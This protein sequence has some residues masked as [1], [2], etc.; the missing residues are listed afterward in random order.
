MWQSIPFSVPYWL[1]ANC[2]SCLHSTGGH[3]TKVRTLRS[4]NR[5]F[6]VVGGLS[7]LGSL[8]LK[9]TLQ[10]GQ[11]WRPRS[12][13]FREE[14]NSW[15][16]GLRSGG[17]SDAVQIQALRG[18]CGGCLSHAMLRSGMNAMFVSTSALTVALI[19][20]AEEPDLQHGPVTF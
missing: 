5:I 3:N 19:F 13:R 11:V 18:V 20:S 16:T 1:E 9:T 15:F 6:V 17:G 12:P 10:D 7:T 8:H 2:R 4:G 14:R